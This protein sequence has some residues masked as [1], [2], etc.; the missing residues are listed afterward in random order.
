M[1][2]W[3]RLT[4]NITN[5]S[6]TAMRSSTLPS[7]SWGSPEVVPGLPYFNEIIPSYSPPHPAIYT[8]PPIRKVSYR[9]YLV[10]S[11]NKGKAQKGLLG[12][13][14]LLAAGA[15]LA[16]RRSMESMR[17]TIGFRV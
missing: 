10:V 12:V 11:Q 4:L 6:T 5:T 3:G 7:M 16:S 2:V 13:E 9:D 17:I 1:W 14:F 15:L 8:S